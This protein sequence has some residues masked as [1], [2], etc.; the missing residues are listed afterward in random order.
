[1][2]KRINITLSR[3]TGLGTLQCVG[4]VHMLVVAW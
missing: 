3:T 4:E 2:A 1:M